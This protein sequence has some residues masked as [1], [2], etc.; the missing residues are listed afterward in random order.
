MPLEIPSDSLLAVPVTRLYDRGIT[1]LSSEILH[2]RIPQAYV[3]I[4]PG[5]VA[6]LE[7]ALVQLLLGGHE[8]SA[9]LRFDEDVPQGVVLVPRSLGLPIDSPEPVTLKVLVKS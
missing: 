3:S 6:G 2:Q 8:V 1:V 5:V 4:K 7:G 9:V